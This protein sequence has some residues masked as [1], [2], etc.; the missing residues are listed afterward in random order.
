MPK[1]IP[2]SWLYILTAYI[3]VSN[4]FSISANS[5]M[6]SMYIWSLIFL[7]FVEFVFVCI[8]HYS[9]LESFSHQFYLTVVHLSLSDSKSPQVSTNL[10][11]ILAERSSRNIL[12]LIVSIHPL[13]SKSF[14]PFINPLVTLPKAT[15]RIGIIATI[16]IHSFF[17]SLARSRYLS[18]F[19]LFSVSFCDHPGQ[20]IRQFCKFSFFFFVD[21]HYYYY[22]RWLTYDQNN[23]LTQRVY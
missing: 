5:L 6:S 11:N 23:G 14:S 9:L 19:S 3:R 22:C 12:L 7:W 15:I 10:L 13:T 8:Y 21:Y 1:S 18:F 16:L 4:S 20:Q 2:K 17:N